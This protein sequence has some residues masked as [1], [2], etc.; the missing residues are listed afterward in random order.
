VEL[1]EAEGEKTERIF[2]YGYGEGELLTSARSIFD[3]E[4]EDPRKV[5]SEISQTIFAFVIR[6]SLSL[7][8][9]LW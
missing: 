4:G 9:S 1:L 5:R 2:E 7:S 3:K 8:L 6:L